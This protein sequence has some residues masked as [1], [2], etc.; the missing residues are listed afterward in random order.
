MAFAVLLAAFVGAPASSQPGSQPA[1]V[2]ISFLAKAASSLPVKGEVVLRP[3][4]PN[5]E[6]VRLAVTSPAELALTLPPGSKWEVSAEIPGFWVARK[7]LSVSSPDQPSLLTLDLWPLGSISGV[8]KFK[9]KGIP[10]PKKVLVK[11]LAVPGFLK[12][13][14]TP[15]GAIDCPV[16]SKG[17]WSCSLPATAYDLVISAEGSTPAYRWGVKVPPGK[18]L[19]L[20]MVELARGASVAGW[21]AVEEGR[22][23]PQRCIA[24]LDLAVAGGGGNLQSVSTLQR[25]AVER[26]VAKDGFFQFAGLAPGTYVL[27]VRQPGYPAVRSQPIR[28]DPGSETLLREPLVLQRPLAFQLEIRPPQDWLGRPWHAQVVRLGERP[29]LPIVF[30]GRAD[31]EGRFAVSGQSAGRFRVIVL[32]S[33]GNHLY[34]HEHAL[35]AASGPQPIEVSFV[36]VEGKVHLGTEPLAATLWFDGRSGANAVKMEADSEG[37]FHGVLS[38]EGAWRIEVQAAM[39]GFPTWTR[40]D[41]Q[42]NRSG[43]ATLDLALPDTRVFG[44]VLDEQGKPVSG[45]DVSLRGEGLDVLTT[46]DS[47]GSFEARGLPEGSVWLG[48]ETSSRASDLVFTTLTEGRE[49]GPIELRLHQTRRLTG[50]VTSPRGPVAGSRVMILARTPRGGGGSAITDT[51]GGFQLDLPQEASRLVAV[52]GAPGF[53]LR[54]FDT[55]AGDKPLLLPLTE[56]QGGLEVTLPLPSDEL[57]RDDLFLAVFQNGLPIP[58]SALGQWA[59]DHGQILD[60]TTRVLRVPEVAPGEYRVCLLPRRLE[61]VLPWSTV[62]E[63][64]TCASG[65]LAPGATLSLKPGKPG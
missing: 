53:A 47:T 32:D 23:E 49:A 46:S 38:R 26:E 52:A 5:Q 61:L 19:S 6:A 57:L 17:S 50:T 15:K 51:S 11:T 21:V 27:E 2:R 45:A 7:E 10:L 33:L 55:Q 48:A 31:E 24:R 60:G 8:V 3:A 25:T 42:A 58:R 62:P 65:F 54:A 9:E 34:S 14:A 13:P 63:G 40:A 12:R 35:D 28:V 37:K 18:T 1:P 16:D 64:P 44:R 59:R 43:K 41:V 22:I 39:P 20:G 4:E 56:E 30:D 36:T 29:P